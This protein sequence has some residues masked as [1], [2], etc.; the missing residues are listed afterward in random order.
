MRQHVFA[1]IGANSLRV[2]YSARGQQWPEEVEYVDDLRRITPSVMGSGPDRVPIQYGGWNIHTMD[3]HGGW[4]STATD[5]ARFEAAFDKKDASPLLSHAMIDT[6]WSRPPKQAAGDVVYYGTGCSVRTLDAQGHINT[7]HNGS[8]DGIYTLMVHRSD[9]LNWVVLLNQRSNAPD[10]PASEDI[11]GM[12]HVAADAVRMWPAGDLFTIYGHGGD[13]DGDG[14]VDPD[15]LVLFEACVSGPMIA[16][17]PE[18][19]DRDFDHDGDVD[20]SDFG[21]FQRC[22]NGANK[23]ADPNCAN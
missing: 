17:L 22:W 5:L 12:L 21:L 7:W 19:R 8:L 1:P 10:T 9:G 18:C 4:V 13:F 20:Q 23:P 15:D 3:S 16:L 6:M 11:D 14:D 2:T